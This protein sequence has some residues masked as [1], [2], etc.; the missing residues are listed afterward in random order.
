MTFYAGVRLLCRAALTTLYHH[1]TI[2]VPNI[3]SGAAIIACNHASHLDAV[4]LGVSFPTPLNWIADDWLFKNRLLALVLRKL[5]TLPVAYDRGEL[6]TGSLLRAR[7][8]TTTA[9]LVLFPRPFNILWCTGSARRARQL[10]I[11]C[12]VPIVP[13][14]ISER[15]NWPRTKRAPAMR[16]SS[17][18]SLGSLCTQGKDVGRRT[19]R[20][21]EHRYLSCLLRESENL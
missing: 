20:E 13:V 5:N 4:C 15:S 18:A 8:A 10:A 16:G 21:G 9:Q 6:S 3:P 7:R 11:A 2:G 1:R 12:N 14:Y 17:A 19:N